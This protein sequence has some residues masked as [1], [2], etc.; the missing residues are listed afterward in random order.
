MARLDVGNQLVWQALK[1]YLPP[2][3]L[4]TSVYRPAQAQFNIIVRN[5]RKEGFVFARE[6]TLND[7]SS[8]LEALLYL[9]KRHYQIA[10]PGKSLHQRALAYDLSGPDLRKIEVAV[11]KAVADKRIRLLHGAPRPIR[12]ENIKNQKC[13]HVEIE[14][15]LLDAEPFDFA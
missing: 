7:R 14:G 2:G 11:R 13:V 3:T 1:F 15:A 6:P 8:W 9:R 10:E 12:I 5:A 4:L